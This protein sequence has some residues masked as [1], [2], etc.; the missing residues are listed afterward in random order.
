M[1]PRPALFPELTAREHDLI[2]LARKLAWT[3][4]A[5]GREHF[6][7]MEDSKAA[8]AFG[9]EAGFAFCELRQLSEGIHD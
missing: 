4:A 3:K 7:E 1:E 8:F 6:T 5:E 2:Q 9:F